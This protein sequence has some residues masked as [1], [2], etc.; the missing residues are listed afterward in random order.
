MEYSI[1][2]LKSKT[3]FDIDVCRTERCSGSDHSRRQTHSLC[4]WTEQSPLAT[5][6]LAVFSVGISRHECTHRLLWLWQGTFYACSFSFTLTV[7]ETVIACWCCYLDSIRVIANILFVFSVV[8]MDTFEPSDGAVNNSKMHLS[9][10][11]FML[12]FLC[13]YGVMNIQWAW[14]VIM[15]CACVCVYIGIHVCVFVEGI[16]RVWKCRHW[17]HSLRCLSTC[18]VICHCWHELGNM[19]YFINLSLVWI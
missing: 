13:D 4:C 1:I 15:H 5:E 12:L 17:W 18:Q 10:Y 3:I 9:A 6:L 14:L 19:L 2:L 8:Q 11:C 16:D 7:D